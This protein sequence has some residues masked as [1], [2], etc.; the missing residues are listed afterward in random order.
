MKN[1]TLIIKGSLPSLNEYISALNRNRYAGNHMKQV[2]TD[3]VYFECRSQ[4]LEAVLEPVI[5]HYTWYMENKRKDVDN[6]SFAKKF[7]N[8][9]LVLAGILVDDSQKY[10]KGFTDTFFIDKNAPRIEI[11][12]EIVK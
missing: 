3:L 6:V 1:Q 11:S 5:I 12:L 7:I 8:D 2:N 10:V 9:G 4:K